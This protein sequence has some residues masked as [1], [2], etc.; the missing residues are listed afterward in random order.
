M[1]ESL[2]SL[3]FKEGLY[4]CFQVDLSSLY[5]T[6]GESSGMEMPGQWSARGC[7]KWPNKGC[8]SIRF[9]THGDSRHQRNAIRMGRLCNKADPIANSGKF[10]R[11]LSV[12][13]ANRGS[14]QCSSDQAAGLCNHDDPDLLAFS[15]V[16]ARLK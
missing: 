1:E 12:S 13:G 10:E 6:I 2:K 15:K 16:E 4:G 5:G 8:K 11:A 7:R 9:A 3:P 14:T